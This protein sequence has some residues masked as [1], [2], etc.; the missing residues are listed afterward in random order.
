MRDNTTSQPAHEYDDNITKTM[1]FY[2]RFHEMILSLTA[3]VKPA[4]AAWLDTGCGTGTFVAKAAAALP[5]TRFT[6]ADPSA[7]ML[8]IAKEKTAKLSGCEYLPLGTEALASPDVTYDVITAVLAHH[9]FDAAGRRAATA[10]CYRMLKPGGLYITYETLRPRTPQGLEIG[11]EW[12]RRAQL[13]SGKNPAGVEKY[14]GRYGVEFFPIT[15]AEHFD[16]LAAAGF[17]TVEVLW[18]SG[19]QVGLYAIK[20]PD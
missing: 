8:A 1:P 5:G 18:L 2:D 11:L 4:P 15:L 12:W 14:I 19:L 7:P 13:S 9:Y 3:V 16:L 17:S 20:Y 6:L 10:N